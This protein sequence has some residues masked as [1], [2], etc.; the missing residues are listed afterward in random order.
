[1]MRKSILALA[2]LSQN[3]IAA[4]D[5][6][7][8]RQQID[9][10]KQDYNSRLQQLEQRLQTY[11]TKSVEIKPVSKPVE[12]KA[13]FNPNISVILEGRYAYFKNDPANYR[14]SGFPASYSYLSGQ[15]NTLGEKGFSL[16]HSEIILS[17][18]IDD[19][20]YGQLTAALHAHDGETKLELEEAFIQTLGLGYGLTAKFG[21]FFSEIGYLN[22]QHPHAWDFVDAPLIYRGMFA[23]QYNDDGVQLSWLA[24]TPFYLNIGTELLK[25]GHFPSSG[26]HSGIGAYTLFAKT[27]GDFNI[28]NSWQAGLSYWKSNDVQQRPLLMGAMFSGKSQIIGANAIW[29]YAPNGNSK[30]QNFKLQTELFEQR[31]DGYYGEY[32][33][34]SLNP[35]YKN[36]HRGGYIQA[37]YQFIPQWRIGLRYDRVESSYV[38]NGLIRQCCSSEKQ[39]GRRSSIMLDWSN[40]EYSRFRLQFN[41]DYSIQEPDNQLFLQYIHSLGSHGAHSF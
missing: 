18:N 12:N 26:E 3:I 32:I 25:G 21:R 20:F 5:V 17:S 1:M 37:V 10:L 29:K 11:E 27:G 6:E 4:D 23:E 33:E 36:R 38:D 41:R 9:Q 14:L 30:S 15:E 39:I 8:L 22:Q 40:S 28:E 35:L 34:G 16:G 13:S 7:T 2:L 24:P 31:D 19:K